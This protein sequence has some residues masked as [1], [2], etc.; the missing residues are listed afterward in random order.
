LY[1]CNSTLFYTSLNHYL[2]LQDFIFLPKIEERNRER[3]EKKEERREGNQVKEGKGRR[4][5][6]RKEK[7]RRRNLGLHS[8]N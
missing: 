2:S 7:K 8:F 3:K 6:R 5:R 1:L 4:R